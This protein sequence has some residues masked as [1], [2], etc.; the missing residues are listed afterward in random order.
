VEQIKINLENLRSTGQ[1]A[2]GLALLFDARH[3]MLQGR[4]VPDS[5]AEISLADNGIAFSHMT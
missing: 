1:P 2:V 4:F 5:V 3:P